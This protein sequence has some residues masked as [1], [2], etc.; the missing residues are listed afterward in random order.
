MSDEQLASLLT[1]YI[2]DQ[3]NQTQNLNVVTFAALR[4]A[5]KTR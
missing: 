4:E 5:C 2:R 1:R 3:P